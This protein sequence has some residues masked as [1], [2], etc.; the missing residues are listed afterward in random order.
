MAGS[1]RKQADSAIALSNKKTKSTAAPK[2]PVDATAPGATASIKKSTVPGVSS[3]LNPATT[4]SNTAAATHAKAPEKFSPQQLPTL[5]TGKFD[6]YDSKLP[7]LVSEYLP[8]GAK[9]PN[10]KAVYEKILFYQAKP[11]FTIRCALR[12]DAAGV[13]LSVGRVACRVIRN[14]MSA[15]ELEPIYVVDG[16]TEATVSFDAGQSVHSSM[17]CD[18]VG[19]EAKLEL[20]VMEG[21][22]DAMRKVWADDSGEK[23]LFEGYFSLNI[24]YGPTL[25]RKQHG[26]GKLYELKFWAVRALKKD[27]EEVGIDAGKG[28][29][30]PSAGGSSGCYDDLGGVGLDGG[31]HSD[32][33][34]DIYGMVAGRRGYEF[35]SDEDDDYDFY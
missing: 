24:I 30:V 9:S 15:E 11:E 14:P 32:D 34:D 2:I 27:G 10:F 8:K 6:L 31:D 13:D 20:D 5:L 1:K 23:E 12:E 21:T 19:Y 16:Q 3:P 17:V 33:E 35:G 28:T 25:R 29:Y 4:S 26:N 18:G 7:L 22:A